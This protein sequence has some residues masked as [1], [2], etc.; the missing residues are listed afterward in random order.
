MQ[1]FC[2][3]DP[4]ALTMKARF[5]TIAKNRSKPDIFFVIELL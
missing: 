2:E 1:H 4:T 5:E 3:G